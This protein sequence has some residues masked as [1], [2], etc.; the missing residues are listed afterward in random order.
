MPVINFM[1]LYFSYFL[2]LKMKT[3]HKLNVTY[4]AVLEEINHSLL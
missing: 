3:I 1:E 2:I 4:N